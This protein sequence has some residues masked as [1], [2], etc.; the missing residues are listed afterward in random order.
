MPTPGRSSRLEVGWWLLALLLV[1]GLS[2]LALAEVGLFGEEL[3]KG[4]GAKAILDGLDV[5]Y[6]ELAFHYYEGGGFVVSHLKALLFALVG[7]SLLAQ[8]LAGLTT[9]VLVF[10]ACWR[11][12]DH[13]FGR[14][15]ARVGALLYLFGPECFQRYSLLSLGIHFEAMAFGVFVLDG[16]LR[17]AFDREREPTAEISHIWHEFGGRAS[18]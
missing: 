16:G 7:E 6:H 12:L 8:R 3:E 14:R 1:R 11:L 17:L 2:I 9:C 5:P 4:A 15:A 18:T 10:A 13:H